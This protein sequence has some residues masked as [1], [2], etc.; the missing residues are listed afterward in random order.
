MNHPLRWLAGIVGCGLLLRLL[1]LLIHGPHLPLFMDFDSWG[2]HRLAVNLLEG[3]GYSW[4][5]T[6][7]YTTNIYR[8]PVLPFALAGIYHLFGVTI[9]PVIVL[10]A[11]IGAATI[12]LVYALAQVLFRD[13][14]LSL[15]AAAVQ[16]FDPIALIYGNLL[17]TEV[18]TCFVVLL[19]AV[20]LVRYAQS[21]R[22]GLLIATGALLG[23]GILVHPVLLFLPPLLLFVPLF[24]ARTRQW[25][26]LAPAGL[27]VLLGLAPAGAWIARNAIVADYPGISCVAA[28]NMLRYKAAGVRADLNGTTREVERDRLAAECEALLPAEATPGARFK[29]WQRRGADILFEHPLIYAKIHLKGCLVELVGPERDNVARLLHGPAVIGADG[30]VTD[31]SIAAVRD[32]S[33]LLNLVR[34]AVLAVQGAILLG[35]FVGVARL[36]RQRQWTLLAGVLLLPAY[37]LLLSGGPEGSPRFRVIYLPFLSL[38]SGVGLLAMISWGCER[39]LRLRAA[40]D[41]SSGPRLIP[42]PP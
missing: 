17:L 30:V 38:L 6:P 33:P 34:W 11:H 9:A 20:L 36:V 1:P 12:V 37:V 39:L 2:Y 41:S 27:A 3:H 22:G 42:A 28:V 18:H 5:L 7:P 31:A 26:S 14:R 15:M 16:A 24:A 40:G 29:L 8:P 10:Q 32:G 25:R 4:E 13:M 23:F 21:G 35:L 19:A